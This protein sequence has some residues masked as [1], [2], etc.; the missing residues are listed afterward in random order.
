[1]SL[2]RLS[3]E[4]VVTALRGDRIS[5][6]RI[7]FP[8]SEQKKI[9]AAI[10]FEVE[11]DLPFDIDDCLIDWE[12]TR[13]DRSS[14]EVVASI[15]KRAD[16]SEI[17]ETLGAAGCAPQTLE[18]E[19]LV[20][21]N[22]T[23]LF[24]LPGT[25]ML[26]DLGHTKSTCCIL[27]DGRAVAART[28][29]VGGRLLTEAVAK[30]RGLD[31][32]RAEQTKH[33]EDV[34]G[35]AARGS[36]PETA[37]VIDRLV[38]EIVRTASSL[39]GTLADL[40]SGPVAKLTLFGGGAQ[41]GGIDAMLSERTG[42]PAACLDRP[43]AGHGESLDTAVPLLLYAPAIA[44]ALRGTARARTR[45]NFLQDEFAVRFDLSRYRR[46]FGSTAM[47]AG[48]A[49][50]LAI[51]SFVTATTLEFRRADA[52]EA[53]VNQLYSDAFPGEAVPDNAATALRQALRDAD[54]RAE[55]LGVYPGNL[56]ALDVLTE[57]S[58][59]IP[60]DL[61]LV[62]EELMIDRQTIRMKVFAKKFESADRLGAE[63]AKFPPF[64]RAQIGAIENV[65]K[66]DGKRFTVTITLATE[67]ERA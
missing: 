4:H 16:V 66:R 28:I 1:V 54:A 9:N 56:S 48:I 10:A 39:E 44:L 26:I 25:R 65:P 63:L 18:T 13:S 51:V 35:R 31:F 62:F 64:A 36:M 47:L 67:E 37:A 22:L 34:V 60:A 46:D 55:F 45:T 20:L 29:P 50:L 21:G 61:E 32:D 17:V 27:V 5:T 57:I 7:T 3:T 23:A 41:L 30:D 38:R 19:G 52:V 14:T 33:E 2:H 58:R 43:E 49:L 15:A 8:F 59:H 42:I 11:E 40:G 24:D 6:R 12:R 53:A